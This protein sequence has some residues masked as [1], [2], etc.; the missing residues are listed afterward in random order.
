MPDS[1]LVQ[2]VRA[3]LL[4]Y[5]GLDPNAVL[6]VASQEGLSGG[7]GD[8]GHAFG[9][10]Q[11]N[12]AGGAITGMFPGETSSQLQDWATSPA[13]LN[14][15]L[16]RINS[17]AGGLKGSQAVAAIVGNRQLGGQ[18]NGFER[19]A[20]EAGEIA[21][22][23]AAYGAPLPTSFAAPAG[24][25]PGASTALPT[26]G[27]AG[28]PAMALPTAP[29]AATPRAGINPLLLGILRGSGINLGGPK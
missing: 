10:F 11:V 24:A 7:I 21:R 4:K 26:P 8:G 13:G 19:P 20:N 9:P 23:T 22:A 1:P 6:A 28:T 5:P 12:N 17:A 14:F 2:A 25:V 29:K 16:Q 15:A 18:Y 3:Q 27:A